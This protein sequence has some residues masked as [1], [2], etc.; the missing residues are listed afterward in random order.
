[1]TAKQTETFKRFNNLITAGQNPALR[2]SIFFFLLL[3][4]LFSFPR[5]SKGQD[6]VNPGEFIVE[7]PTLTNLGFEWK[8]SGDVNRNAT[9]TVEYRVAG[10]PEWKKALPLLRIGDEHV[11]RAKENLDYTVP[12]MFAGSILDVAPDTEYEC[13]FTMEDVDKAVKVVKIAKVR[14]RAEPKAYKGGRVLHVYPA[15][16]TGEKKEPSFT[17]LLGAYYGSGL[18]D[19]N[20]VQERTINPGDIIE[21]HAGLYEADRRNYVNPE[22]V[23]F[24]GTYFLTVRATEE[25]P[26]VIRSAGDGEVIFDGAGAHTFFDVSATENHIFE[27]LTFR[28]ADIVFYAGNKHMTGAKGLTIRKCRME[29]IGEGI[30]TEYAGSKNF[31]IADNVLIGRDDRYRLLGWY[32]AKNIYGVNKMYSYIGIKVCGSGHVICHNAVAFFHDGIDISTY[33]TPEAEQE[34][35][36]VSVDIYNNDIHVMADDFIESDGGVHNIRVMRNRGV[37]AAEHG[38]SAQPVFGGPVY[39][40]RNVL[41]NLPLGGCLK[42]N[43]RP[44]GLYVFHNTFIGDNNDAEL[45]SNAHFRNNLILGNDF[46]GRIITSFPMA[47]SYSTYDYDGYRPNL[48][49]NNNYQWVAP[50]PGQFQNYSLSFQSDGKTFNSLKDLSAATGLEKHG[51]EIDYDIFESLQAPDPTKPGFVYHATDLNFRLKPDSKA[52]D[53]GIRLPDVNDD[54]TG[55]LPDL[56]ALEAGKPEPVYGPRGEIYN[57]PFY[58]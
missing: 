36:T 40:I 55:K 52:V 9:V 11:G 15:N 20:V 4:L 57:R 10:T 29:N 7:P 37:N 58:R 39:F 48:K 8:I 30:I 32:N 5:V 51:I 31:Y 13:R 25:K 19:W 12:N 22:G 35:K 50:H 49:T 56:G 18:G 24:D 2:K 28:N 33:G 26:I 17:S 38:L 54:F 27:G 53:T 41:Y 44:A 1:M 45:Y 43:A 42:V 34:L 3:M 16:W 46:P 6:Q 14:T 23:P 47:T 21:V